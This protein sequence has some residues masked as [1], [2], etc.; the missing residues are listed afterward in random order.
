MFHPLK[1]DACL[2]KPERITSTS[3]W[4][5]HLPAAFALVE[6][7]QPQVFVELGTHRGDSYCAFCQAVEHLQLGTQCYAV[8][9]W[10]GDE[11]SGHYGD[12]ILEELRHYHDERYGRF[13]KLL[14]ADFDTARRQF[15][16]G[17]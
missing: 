14:R 17:S 9:T 15:A 10:Q 4:A 13:S 7:L 5:H 6:A 12:E 16:D 3:A 2:L 11:H 1:T 8:D